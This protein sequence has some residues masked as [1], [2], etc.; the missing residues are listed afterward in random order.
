MLKT[1]ISKIDKKTTVIGISVI[2]TAMVAG[3]VVFMS[4]EANTGTD[5]V[6][7]TRNAS[8]YYSTETA[9][10]DEN[11]KAAKK[12]LSE[13]IKNSHAAMLEKGYTETFYNAK[14]KQTTIS[15][16]DAATKKTYVAIPELEFNNEV[17]NN[18]L[19]LPTTLKNNLGYMGKK[20]EV[21]KDTITVV[22]DGEYFIQTFT[23]KDGLITKILQEHDGELVSEANLEYEV[24]AKAKEYIDT[25]VV[26]ESSIGDKRPYLTRSEAKESKYWY[27]PLPPEGVTLLPINPDGSIPE[28]T[29]T[30]TPQSTDLF[31]K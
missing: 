27:G 15:I 1:L 19:F 20:W 8:A 17:P 28:P 13:Y 25:S 10:D 29:V 30:P 5:A 7:N 9:V 31:A 22:L 23:I 11:A 6:I 24:T 21:T 12:Y 16:Y 2:A 3:S 26:F 4:G 14:T 18:D